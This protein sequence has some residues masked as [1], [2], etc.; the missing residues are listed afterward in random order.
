M[1]SV[2]ALGRR[3]RPGRLRRGPR[4]RL[5][6][7]FR[8]GGW[9]PDGQ[10]AARG[11]AVAIGPSIRGI[12]APG[13]VARHHTAPAAS[14]SV[15]GRSKRRPTP[16]ASAPA[17]GAGARSSTSRWPCPAGLH[18]NQGGPGRR[19][20]RGGRAPRGA[21][22]AVAGRND[23]RPRAPWTDG[24]HACTGVGRARRAAASR[25]C[26]VRRDR[27]RPAAG[28]RE[29]VMGFLLDTASRTAPLRTPTSVA[30]SS[31]PGLRGIARRA[32][33]RVRP[34]KP[35]SYAASRVPPTAGR[36]SR[37]ARR[38]ASWTTTAADDDPNA[39]WRDAA[40]RDRR[41][42]WP[43]RRGAPGRPPA[44][45]GVPVHRWGRSGRE[46]PAGVGTAGAP[47]PAAS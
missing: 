42:R 34:P 22:A 12:V 3:A 36:G 4:L 15:L 28:R 6:Q 20:A 26:R 29:P 7:P 25:R 47:E 10:R 40:A 18:R 38:R 32:G 24:I 35:A 37:V 19:H 43:G 1:A 27:G 14:R 8:A 46:R 30:T 39:P 21:A 13:C 16:T 33:P 31:W 44:R 23:P 45:L 9:R 2:A 11:A 17:V 41:D 5:E